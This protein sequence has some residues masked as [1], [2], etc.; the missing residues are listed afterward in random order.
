MSQ[1]P[2][3]GLRRSGPRRKLLPHHRRPLR[4]RWPRLGLHHPAV[5]SDGL[6]SWSRLGPR[7]HRKLAIYLAYSLPGPGPV[8][9]LSASVYSSMAMNHSDELENGH[10]TWK[11]PLKMLKFKRRL[12]WDLKNLHSSC[13]YEVQ[14]FSLERFST[15]KSAN[16]FQ[17]PT[18]AFKTTTCTCFCSF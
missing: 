6:H 18:S 11:Q 8:L 9:I 4:G 10:M 17:R 16:I 13:T 1:T 7:D 14:A 2:I 12:N 3:S 15:Y 5:L